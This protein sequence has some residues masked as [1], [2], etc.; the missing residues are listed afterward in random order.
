M[1]VRIVEQLGIIL[2]LNYHHTAFQLTPE[3]VLR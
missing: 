1:A 3:F 2:S